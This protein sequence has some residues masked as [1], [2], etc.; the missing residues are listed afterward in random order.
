M[1]V[2]T[3]NTRLKQ[4]NNYL[5]HVGQMITALCNKEVKKIL[6]HFMPNTWR[7]KMSEKGYNSMD[8]YFQEM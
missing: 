7:K 5:D 3:F 2:H 1:K 4:L 6:Y 8:R